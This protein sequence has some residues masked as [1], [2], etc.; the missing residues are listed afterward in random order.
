MS[1]LPPVASGVTLRKS[2]SPSARCALERGD[3]AVWLAALHRQHDDGAARLPSPCGEGP[4]A[5]LGGPRATLDAPH[6]T[7][8]PQGGEGSLAPASRR[9]RH[10]GV[11]LGEGVPAAVIVVVGDDRPRPGRRPVDAEL[12]IRPLRLVLVGERPPPIDQLSAVQPRLDFRQ[13]WRD[14]K[15]RKTKSCQTPTRKIRRR[16]RTRS[17]CRARATR[18]GRRRRSRT[19]GRRGSGCAIGG[20][21]EGSPSFAWSCHC[22]NTQPTLSGRSKSSREQRAEAVPDLLVPDDVV[23]IAQLGAMAL[24]RHSRPGRSSKRQ[25]RL[26]VPHHLRLDDRRVR[27]ARAASRS[28]RRT[29]RV[30]KS[31]CTAR[32]ACAAA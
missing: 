30:S 5:R 26:P 29:C 27:R 4:G 11:D 10:G 6:P 13:P 28:S 15:T 7:L 17:G 25:A 32:N 14:Q 24:A 16:W 20:F 21:P 9:A 22:A 2:P 8:S 23:G 18:P 1:R 19:A 3:C 12:E 31:R